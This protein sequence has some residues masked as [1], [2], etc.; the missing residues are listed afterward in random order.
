MRILIRDI[1]RIV[2]VL[3]EGVLECYSD[4]RRV[5]SGSEMSVVDS[6]DNAYLFIRN[7]KIET[8]GKM[9]DFP[10]SDNRADIVINGSGRLLFPSFCDSHTHLLY[11]GSREME[12]F[13][14]IKGLTYKEIA[15][16]GGGIL[17]SAALLRETSSEILLENLMMRISEIAEKGTG[18]VEIK[19]GY[20]LNA[21]EELRMLRIIKKASEGSYLTVKS[22]LLGAH[23]IP[24][25]FDGNSEAFANVVI[26][27]MIPV[28]ATEGL[29]DFIDVFCEDGFFTIT[30][31]DRI[32]NAAIK[33]GLRPKVHANQL[34]FSGGVQV[35][36]K[37]GAISADHL[38]STAVEEFKL[39]S[40]SGTMPVLLPGSSLFLGME[41]AP[42]R[43]M[44]D[45]G[46]PVAIASN[47]NPG[48]S[49]SGDLRFM[50]FLGALNYK[51]NINEL[52][53]SVTLNAASA[54][55]LDSTHGIIAPGHP[56]DLFLT[57][58]IAGEEFF[59]YSYT[60]PLI[61][62]IILKGKIQ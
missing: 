35:A 50:M 26:N 10:E 44:I 16:R 23:A 55:D 8:Y 27:E 60:T 51:M 11:A 40:E 45:Y 39:L 33:Y 13:D 62:K 30:D 59:V 28:A 24:P 7:G 41:F 6:I 46:L 29:A 38:E 2:Q 25:E 52:I 42:G 32:L 12:F 48:S 14:K 4:G 1:K 18:A 53:N 9:S 57:K 19:S 15:A 3:P 61:D 22:T 5:R 49:P 21:E 54:M 17:N 34:S 56:A 58:P 47:Y 20:G 36:A 37:Y 43:D 31:T